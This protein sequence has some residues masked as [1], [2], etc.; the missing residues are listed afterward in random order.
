MDV[1]VHATLDNTKVYKHVNEKFDL[2]LT[3]KQVSDY[4]Y[5]RGLKRTIIKKPVE[6]EICMHY[7]QD[8]HAACNHHN[9]EYK[10]DDWKKV[11]CGNCLKY[12]ERIKKQDEHKYPIYIA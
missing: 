1:I 10:S 2:E 8:G 12:K 3:V 11:T 9:A 4:C 6:K 7:N 5:V